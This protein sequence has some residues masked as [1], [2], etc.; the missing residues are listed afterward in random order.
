[1][2]W[3]TFSLL[4]GLLFAASRVVARFV[5]RKQGNALAFTALHDFI[6]GLCLLPFLFIGFHW[7][8]QPITWLYFSG[9]VVFAFLCDWLA[10]LALRLI[11]VSLYQIV[12]QV[13][14]IF[15][16]VGGLLLFQ[17][18][19]TWIKVVAIVLITLGV[20]VAVSEKTRFTLNRGVILSIISTLFAIVAFL[21][22]KLAVRDF[23]ETAA[24]SLELMLIGILA[25]SCL[26][27]RPKPLVSELRLQKWGL[28]VSGL[29]FGGFEV[30]LF[31]ALRVG[32][33]SRVIPVTQS[34]VVFALIAGLV[35]LRE[36]Q[37]L[38]QKISGAI[39]IGVGIVA[40]Y[41]L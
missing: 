31:Y 12:N 5:L 6:A 25:F 24:A 32:E 19:I 30:I 38:P 18:S 1:M 3:F 15:V 27:F 34:S 14:H 40:M 21:F 17:E 36:R 39:L 29:L 2:N 26:G 4:A 35:F 33:A 7:P 37:R 8:T 20:G 22:A 9:V 10:F 11:D 23:S 13:R 16:L 41:L 28:V